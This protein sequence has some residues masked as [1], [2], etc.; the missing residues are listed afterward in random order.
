MQTHGF[1]NFERLKEND[2]AQDEIL[3]SMDASTETAMGTPMD[4]LTDVPAEKP[5][6]ALMD[7]P[8]DARI[9]TQSGCARV[10]ETF[11]LFLLVRCIRG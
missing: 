7:M 11:S 5:M 1:E 2:F 3:A 10:V 8:T 4:A 6:I 9:S